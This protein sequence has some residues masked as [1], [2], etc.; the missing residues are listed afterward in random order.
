MQVA[1]V[2]REDAAIVLQEATAQQRAPNRAK[3][4]RLEP[5]AMS[6]PA[7]VW[8]VQF[9][10][11]RAQG[12]LAS[13]RARVCQGIRAQELKIAQLVAPDGTALETE[14]K[15]VQNVKQAFTVP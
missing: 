3:F 10:P 12:V 1:W 15:V 4:V 8:Y 9:T 2:V 13:R 5:T 6:V 11:V 7:H 14:L